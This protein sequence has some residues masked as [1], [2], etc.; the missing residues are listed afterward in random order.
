M[1]PSQDVRRR[2][3]RQKRG[4]HQPRQLV[5]RLGGGRRRPGDEIDHSAGLSQVASIGE[6]VDQFRPLAVVHAADNA[7]AMLVAE[8]AILP[9]MIYGRVDP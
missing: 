8:E 4:R 6:R 5:V 3:D 2:R 9:P 1:A 7:A